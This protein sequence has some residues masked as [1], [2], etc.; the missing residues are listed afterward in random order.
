[1]RATVSIIALSTLFAAGTAHADLVGATFGAGGWSQN[2]GGNVNY[3]GDDFDVD[4][5]LGLDEETGGYAYAKLEH[6][7]PVLPNVRLFYQEAS[8]KGTGT[9][10]ESR[11]F[12]G[13]TFSANEEVR[14]EANLDHIDAALYYEVLDNVVS[15]DIGLNFRYM[16]G[17]VTVTR[18]AT[19]ESE[20]VNLD[21]V[22]PMAYA[23]LR[24]DIPTTGL[25]VKAEGSFVGY[26]G[27]RIADVMIGGGYEF[28]LVAASIGVEAGYKSQQIKLDDVE[29]ADADVSVQGPYA[30][31]VVDF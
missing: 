28:D 21:V 18:T 1:M 3:E 17:D 4:D 7:V 30:G 31:V 16:T 2:P 20:K 11:S 29:D 23:M 14:S 26:S 9:V 5:E 22:L 10:S 19:G 12:G 13:I 15:A 8:F 24:A 6:P 25:F 27:N